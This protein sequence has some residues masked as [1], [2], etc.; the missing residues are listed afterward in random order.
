MYS[1][2]CINYYGP[3]SVTINAKTTGHFSPS[4][5][6]ACANTRQQRYTLHTVQYI[7]ENHKSLSVGF[8]VPMDSSISFDAILYVLGTQTTWVGRFASYWLQ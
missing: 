5:S 4:S 7:E 8:T 6:M 2:L 1:R 3:G